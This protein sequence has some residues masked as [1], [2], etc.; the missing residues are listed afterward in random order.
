MYYLFYAYIHSL[1]INFYMENRRWNIDI[2]DVENSDGCDPIPLNIMNNYFSVGV[3]S[4]SLDE[5]FPFFHYSIRYRVK[6]ATC[7]PISQSQSPVVLWDPIRIV[8]WLYS[9]FSRPSMYRARA[10]P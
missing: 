7:H 5:Y 2:T 9:S 8:L 6:K 3:V 4:K 1:F 10:S